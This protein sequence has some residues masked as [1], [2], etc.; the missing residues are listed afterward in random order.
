M[1]DKKTT[2]LQLKTALHEFN[3]ARDWSQY[4]NPRNL[5][6][7]VSVEANELLS[8]FLWSS[9]N[10]PQPP[11]SSRLQNVHDE[12]ADVMICLI[13]FCNSMN[14]DLTQAVNRKIQ[15][16]NAKYPVSKSRGKLEKHD[17]L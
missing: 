10:G 3:D 2:I 9:D 5:A 17:E 6:M 4:H 16:N 11:V 15:A 12:V 1:N 7:A 8:L 14:I 13:N